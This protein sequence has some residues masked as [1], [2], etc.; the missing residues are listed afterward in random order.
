LAL[1]R[2]LASR[3]C[4]LYELGRGGMG[5]VWLAEHLTLRSK[6]AVKLIDPRLATDPDIRRRFEREA[7]AAAALRSPHVVQVLDFG[8]DE[9]PYLVM[10]FL[11]GETLAARLARDGILP[12]SDAWKVMSQ[13]ARA[14]IRAHQQDIVHRDLKPDNIFLVEEEPDFFVKV[15]DFGIAKA[16]EPE[17]PHPV[18]EITR[19]GVLLGTPLHMSPE[20]AEGKPVDARSDLWSMGVVAFECI[21][22]RRPFDGA[23]LLA[24]LRAICFDPILV[25]SSVAPVP[26]GFDAWFAKATQ[27]NPDHR[28]Q[29]AR[30]LID[31]LA[32]V[33]QSADEPRRT[34]SYPPEP[35]RSTGNPISTYPGVPRERRKDDRIPSSIPAGINEQRDLRHTALIHNASRS[36][37]L[38]ATRHQCHP[39]ETLRLAL[40]LGGKHHGESISARVIRVGARTN[41]PIWKFD[42]GV[43]FDLPLD[44]ELLGEIERRAT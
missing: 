21:T 8:V 40:Q 6:V 27:R 20:Q 28:F 19:S 13:V 1:E 4:L 35:P 16:L 31:A 3:Y 42:V 15:L 37:A 14:M 17:H 29:T 12:T 18:T 33:L 30:E 39:G 43:E 32:P 23:S 25:P 11:T 38:L 34:S 44:D 36:G 10:E 5:S 9:S 2:I 26:P 41:D 24:V 7:R 22:G